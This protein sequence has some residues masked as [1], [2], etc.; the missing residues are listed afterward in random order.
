MSL[1]PNTLIFF[2]AKMREAFAVQKS[3][4]F[5]TKNIGVLEILTYEILMKHQ[6]G[7]DVISFE[8]TTPGYFSDYCPQRYEQLY[9][10]TF[11]SPTFG[12]ICS[13]VMG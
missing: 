8:Q 1:F 5:S 12:L 13:F 4:I 6:L 7:N 11:S 3:N 2:V 9:Y 10:I